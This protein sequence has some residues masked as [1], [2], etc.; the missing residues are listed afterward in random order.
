[1]SLKNVDLKSKKILYEL[2]VDGFQTNSAIAKKVGLSKQV[3]GYRVKNMEEQGVIRKVYTIL[4]LEKLGFFGQKLYFRM[5][6]LNKETEQKVIEYFKNHDKVP[7]FGIYEGGFDF[8][9]SIFDRSKVDF[10]KTLSGILS[11]LQEFVNDFEIATYASVYAFKKNYL[12]NKKTSSNF[13]FVGQKQGFSE[14]KESD[15]SILRLLCQDSR[16]PST[17][18]ARK[19]NISADAVINRVKKLKKEGIIQGSRL[20]LNKPKM[21]IREFKILLNLK[22]YD[23]S[24]HKKFVSYSEHNKYIVACIKTIGPWN[25]EL[26]V[27]LPDLDLLHPLLLELKTEFAES[28]KRV[29]TLLLFD[30]YKYNFY[31]FK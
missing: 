22:N 10:D 14:L 25:L 17:E 21:G 8:V 23:S 19:L 26:D 20:M 15:K 3:V 31:P 11:D 5:Q 12:I 13:S 28:I 4:N 18:M 1:M 6:N 27:E 24:V 9:V 30:E 16:T 7:W 29:E 2:D